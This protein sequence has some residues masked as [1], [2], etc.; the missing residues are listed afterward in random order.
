[1]A[2]ETSVAAASDREGRGC[3][4]VSLLHTLVLLLEN[5]I[6]HQTPLAVAFLFATL[7]CLLSKL[8]NVKY[9][10]R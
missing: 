5:L 1:V 4:A 2:V 8:V 10:R 3:L 6:S 7:I 9:L